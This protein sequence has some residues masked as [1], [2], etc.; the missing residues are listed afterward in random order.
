VAGEVAIADV[1]PYDCIV[2]MTEQSLRNLKTD[3][4]D[5]RQFHV[6]NPE[7]LASDDWRRGII[8]TGLA[9]TVQVFYNIFDQSPQNNLIPACLKHNVGVLARCPLDEGALAGAVDE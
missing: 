6:W 8:A 4:I 5:L 2:D 7:W 1:F 3:V 9:D